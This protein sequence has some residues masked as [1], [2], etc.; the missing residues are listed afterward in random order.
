MHECS[1]EANIKEVTEAV[2][3]LAKLIKGNG[4]IGIAEQARRAFEYTS[5]AST[6]KNGFYD[7]LFRSVILIILTYL[8]AKVGL[9]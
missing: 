3:E 8:A 7:W 9:K 5:C 4:V 2:K 6:S 1:Q